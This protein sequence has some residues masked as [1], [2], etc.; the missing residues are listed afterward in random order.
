[1]VDYPYPANFLEPLPA[2]P[3]KVVC[4]HLQDDTLKGDKLL[5][6]VADAVGVYYNN[7]GQ[8]KCFNTSQQAVS[9]LGDEGWYFQVKT[10]TVQFS[11]NF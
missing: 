7:S 5:Q 8:A 11:V 4:K 3:I 9:C 6:A 1:M 10:K 2:W